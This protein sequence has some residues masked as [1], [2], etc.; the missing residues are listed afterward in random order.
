MDYADITRTNIKSLMKKEHISIRK[1][2][3]IIGTSASTLTD[4][5]KSKKGICIDNMMLIAQHFGVSVDLLCDPEFDPDSRALY[6]QD[7]SML[8]H[9]FREL[10]DHG[11]ELVSFVFNKELERVAQEKEI[12]E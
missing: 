4:S 1:L 7:P 3:E 2:A 6:L 9:R 5:L 12:A 11:K 10:D 8:A